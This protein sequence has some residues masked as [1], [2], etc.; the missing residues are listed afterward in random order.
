M[1]KGRILD[2]FVKD[3]HILQDRLKV[4]VQAFSMLQVSSM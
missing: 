4:C 2:A 1:M 3:A